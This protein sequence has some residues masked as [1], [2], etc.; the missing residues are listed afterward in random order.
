MNVEN[1][2]SSGSSVD[3]DELPTKRLRTSTVVTRGS[4]VPATSL[5]E[6]DETTADSVRD[7]S[8]PLPP[9]P[10]GV[11]ISLSPIEQSSNDTGISQGTPPLHAQQ[12]DNVPSDTDTEPS[13]QSPSPS[14]DV[15]LTVPDFLKGKR[16]IYNYLTSVDEPGFKLLLVSYI[17]FELADLSGIRGA[18]P[19]DFRP[20]AIAWWSSRA[21]PN[22]LPPYDSFSSFTNT[23]VQWWI[24]M[25]PDWRRSGLRC[26][27]IARD[28]GKLESLYQ[29]GING[30]LNIV[31]LVYWWASI[32]EE[33]G[34]P[35]G[36]AYHWLL[37]DVTWVLSQLTLIAKKGEFGCQSPV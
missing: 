14:L 26:G 22:K 12:V 1:N 4:K 18:L 33:R 8:T 32:L 23:I 17:K 2:S 35:A 6:V 27:T 15:E 29:P 11:D 37:A 31:I 9:S 13:P 16:D 24:S 5:N 20:K 19:T 3:P 10:T 30:L 25:Q 28:E 36:L 21:R 7:V 34:E